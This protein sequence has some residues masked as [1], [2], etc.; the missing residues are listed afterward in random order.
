MCSDIDGL[1][2]MMVCIVTNQRAAQFEIG[3]DCNVYKACIDSTFKKL[4]IS[5]MN[6]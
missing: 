5:A 2:A 1:L 3:L 4:A 6:L